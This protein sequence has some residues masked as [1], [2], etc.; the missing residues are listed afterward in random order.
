VEPGGQ[1][2]VFLPESDEATCRQIVTHLHL[3]TPEDV[4]TELG[5]TPVEIA[6]DLET[7][8]EGQQYSYNTGAGTVE[9]EDIWV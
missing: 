4:I 7:P 2:L 8:P 6:G 5:L 3:W 1:I 9:L